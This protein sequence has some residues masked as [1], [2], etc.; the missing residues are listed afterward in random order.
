LKS[1]EEF[2]T[3]GLSCKFTDFGGDGDKFMIFDSAGRSEPLLLDESSSKN[4]TSNLLELKKEVERKSRDLKSS[5]KF[6]RDF[7]RVFLF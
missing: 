5:E 4:A 2:K 1:G 6:L 3:E 7:I